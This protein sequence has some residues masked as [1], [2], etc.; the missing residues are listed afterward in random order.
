MYVCISV[1]VYHE[2]MIYSIFLQSFDKDR[3]ATENKIDHWGSPLM[4]LTWKG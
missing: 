4:C 3:N 2:I 1:Y